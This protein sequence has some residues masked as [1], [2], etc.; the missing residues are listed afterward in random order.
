MYN[1]DEE[2]KEMVAV[3]KKLC[4]QR[5]MSPH[6][7]AKKAGISESTMSYI[8]KGKTKPQ[9]YTVLGLCNALGVRIGDLFDERDDISESVGFVT[10]DEKELVNC[11]RCLS[12]QKRELLRIYI[13]MLQQYEDKRLV[14]EWV[15]K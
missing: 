11:Y 8:M 2:C 6:A 12:D 7:L 9:V 14:K 5:G 15:N 1:P 3:L 4:E 10:F 13:D